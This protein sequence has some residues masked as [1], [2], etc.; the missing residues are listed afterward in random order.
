MELTVQ[1]LVDMHQSVEEVLPSIDDSSTNKV[2]NSRDQEVVDGLGQCHLP[3]G[4][5]RFIVC[6][7]QRWVVTASNSPGQQGM[8][9]KET[10]GDC[11]SVEADEAEHSGK[12]SLRDTDASSPNS[13]VIFTLS[14]H[15][16]RLGQ[17]EKS[18]GDD[19]DDL[20]QDNIAGDLKAGDVVAFGDFFGRV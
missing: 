12:S 8:S 7:H 5:S 4:E 13:D 2:L 19:L 3:R 9:V 11:C 6:A 17:G 15:L 20:L 16:R 1:P 18:A 14:N 10:L